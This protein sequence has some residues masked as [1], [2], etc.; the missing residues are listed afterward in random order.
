MTNYSPRDMLQRGAICTHLHGERTSINAVEKLQ[1]AL[2][3]GLMEQVEVTLYK[4][5]ST[6]PGSIDFRQLTLANSR[7]I[8]QFTIQMNNVRNHHL[9]CV[10]NKD[11]K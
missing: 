5:N 8:R 1:H 7:H 11:Q 6:F 9:V 3:N 4:K 2:D 10:L